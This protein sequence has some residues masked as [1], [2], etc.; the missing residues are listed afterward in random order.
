MNISEKELEAA[1]RNY[2]LHQERVEYWKKLGVELGFL[3]EE[4]ELVK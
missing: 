1:W 2:R 4:G 3:N